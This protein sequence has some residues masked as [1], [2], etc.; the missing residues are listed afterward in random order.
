[1]NRSLGIAIVVL[2]ALDLWAGDPWKEK[3]YKNWTEK[4]VGKILNESPWAKRVDVEATEIALTGRDGSKELPGSEAGGEGDGGAESRGSEEG[5]D[6]K[7]GSVA[8][9]IRWVSARTMREAWVRGEVL[10]KRV[11]ELDMERAL[12]PAPSD[13]EL[14]VV[15]SGTTLFAG[16]D[17]VFQLCRCIQHHAGF[18]HISISQGAADD[19]GVDS[20][21]RALQLNFALD[22]DITGGAAVDVIRRQD[23]QLMRDRIL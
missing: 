13:Y 22:D 8:F 23:G 21:F 12:P 15:G 20:S 3:P 7:K 1:M 11:A 14:L 9:M 17:G 10:Q 16:E 19:G 18:V 5:S 6:E 2:L 4:D